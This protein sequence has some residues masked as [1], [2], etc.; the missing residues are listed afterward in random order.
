MTRMGATKPFAP[1][2]LLYLLVLIAVVAIFNSPIIWTFKISIEE[3]DLI[4]KEPLA[5]LF[6]P[7][8]ASYRV[9]FQEF[10]GYF[11]N[12]F[13]AASGSTLLSIIIGF[14]TAYS[15]ARFRTGGEN[16]SFWILSLRFIPPVA[17]L[18]PIYIWISTIGLLDNIF[19]LIPVYLILN[20]PLSI[21]FLRSFIEEIPVENEEAALID[22]CSRLEAMLR[23]TLPL[24][25]P[26]IAAVSVLAFIASWNE[27]LCALVLTYTRART[28]PV[29]LAQFIGLYRVSYGELAAAGIIGMLPTIVLAIVMRNHLVRGMT[30]GVLK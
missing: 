8:I 7:T 6:N 16:L 5:L 1:R 9:L 22:G 13:L 26:A 21:W 4:F 25:R 10:L 28:W 15:I 20:L 30:L 19:G 23:I 29:A 27:Y 3:A 24:S 14:P 11:L 17:F 2:N 18:I 12:S